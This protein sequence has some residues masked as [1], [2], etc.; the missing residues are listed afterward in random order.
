MASFFSSSGRPQHQVEVKIDVS[1]S[2]IVRT[3]RTKWRKEKEKDS[4][5]KTISRFFLILFAF[6]YFASYQLL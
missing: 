6:L 4:L 3:E 5:R 1:F 2:E